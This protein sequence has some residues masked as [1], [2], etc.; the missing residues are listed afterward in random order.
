MNNLQVIVHD[1]RR[2][3]TTGQLAE[4]YGTDNKRI[5]NNFNENKD[6]YEEGKHFLLLEG[7][8]LKRFKSES[9][10][11]GFAPNLNKLYLW[12]EKGAWLHAKSL[13]TDKAWDA[14]EMLV[15]EYYKMLEVKP[16]TQMEIIAAQAQQMV[17]QERKM[18][19]IEQKQ[20][21]LQI[22]HQSMKEV[23]GAQY[24]NWRKS[25]NS[26]I[27]KISYN[28]G[29]KQS[30]VRNIAYSLLEDRAKCKLEQ[31]LNNM[32]S[33]CF[34]EKN[35]S[36]SKINNLKTLDVIEND[37]KLVQIFVSIVKELAIKYGI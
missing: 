12:T 20:H 2:V 17:E 6:R 19:E 35:W 25:T 33:R 37:N 24:D 21:S 29:M 26:I 15:D 11:S 7:E 36:N 34:K 13:N 32:R 23:L 16:M 22:E 4:S 1:N 10:I 8:E 27:N 9:L 18:K 14:Y 5:S 28:T 30:E 3:L 31:R